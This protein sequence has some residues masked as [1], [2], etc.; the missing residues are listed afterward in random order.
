MSDSDWMGMVSVVVGGE[1]AAGLA[2]PAVLDP[3]HRGQGEQ[4]LGDADEDTRRGPPTV[5]LQPELVLERV[6]HA[7]NPLA[8]PAK[9][10][11]PAWLVRP[12]PAQHDPAQLPHLPLQ[13]PPPPPP[14]G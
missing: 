14:F 13:G 2:N 4:A 12:G 8:D 9:R 6:D 3:Q 11:V 5:L 1:V 7:L 10:P